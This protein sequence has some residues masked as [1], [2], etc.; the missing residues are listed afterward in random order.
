MVIDSQH[1]PSPFAANKE[2]KQCLYYVYPILRL[3]RRMRIKDLSGLQ[4][5]IFAL[6]ENISTQILIWNL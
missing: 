2:K 1:K 6:G 3:Y 4:I 5:F